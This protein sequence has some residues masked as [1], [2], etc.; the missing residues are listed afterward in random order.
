MIRLVLVEL[1]RYRSRRAIALLVLLAVALS[2]AVA[3]KTAYDSRPMSAQ[4]VATAKAQADIEAKRTDINAD[5]RNCIA[6]PVRY[7]GPGADAGTCRDALTPAAR[8]YLPRKPLDLAGTLQGNGIG[9]ALLVICLLVIAASTYSGGDWATRS[10]TNQVLFEPRRLRLWTAKAIAVGLACGL[11]ALV[12]L[13]GFWLAAYLVASSRDLT[14]T[15]TVLTDVGLHVLR[16]VVLATAAGIGAYALAMLF[17]HT[18]GTLALLFAYSVG[19][20][21]LVAL[22]V[23]GA[24]RWSLGNNVFAWLSDDSDYFDP[25]AGV[26]KSLSHLDAGLYLAALLLIACLASVLS[27]TRRDV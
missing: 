19:G 10:M 13:G 16:A 3:F 12:T 17:R 22:F 7:L 18:V 2:A 4:E 24:A 5:L 1:S 21:L 27:F 25:A 8:S 14:P 26:L 23:G 9:L 20:E 15:D 11:V 6:N